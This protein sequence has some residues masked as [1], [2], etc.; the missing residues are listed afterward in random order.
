MFLL[1]K[2][3]RVQ[4][5]RIKKENE[6]SDVSYSEAGGTLGQPPAGY[7]VDHHRIRLGESR[8]TFEQARSAFRD[9]QMFRMC[10]LEPCWPDHP[11]EQGTLVGTLARIFGVWSVNVCR[12]V[13]VIEET[14]DVEKFGFAYGTLPGHVECGE[15]RFTIEW[16]HDDDTVWYDILAFSKPGLWLTW[17][18]DPLVRRLQKR[19]AV[20]SMQSMFNAVQQNPSR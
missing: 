14:G 15:E 11:I 1:R 19:F 3:G 8:E 4:L 18:S 16:H 20:D 5:E 9:W 7:K 2:P 10:W 12:I 13:S 6:H 17:L